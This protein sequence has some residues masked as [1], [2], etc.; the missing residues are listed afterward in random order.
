LP[1]PLLCSTCCPGTHSR[2]DT[3]PA[4]MCTTWGCATATHTSLV[5]VCVLAVAA[6]HHSRD[7]IGHPRCRK[8]NPPLGFRKPASRIVSNF[9]AIRYL[10][11]RKSNT[12]AWVQET[13][14]FDGLVPAV[15]GVGDG[16]AYAQ[17]EAQ[18]QS[19]SPLFGLYPSGLMFRNMVRM[20]N[21][22]IRSTKD[23]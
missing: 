15:V 21:L 10:R 19:E 17:A 3:S 4:S 1:S 6:W 14:L 11:C 18:D 9:L 2:R 16:V 5:S 8:S 23:C 20:H 7:V 13:C 22:R 12:A